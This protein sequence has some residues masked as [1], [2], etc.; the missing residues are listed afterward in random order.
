[1]ADV[2][3]EKVGKTYG[4]HRI[5][6][7]FS[8]TIQDGECFTFLGPSG[9]GKTVIL[10]LIAGFERLTDGRIF[11]G[12]QLVSSAKDNI[13]LPPE[14]RKIGMVFQDYAVWPH[15]S[16]SENIVYPLQMQKIEAAAAKERTLAAVNLVNLTGLE[17]RMPFQLS[18]G[19]QQ[20]VALARALVSRPRVMLLDEPLSNLDANLREEMRF[21][22]TTLQK[23]TGVT[24]LYVTHDQEVA[25]AISD[26]VAV[27]D[28][29]G[30]I[31][32]IG[33]PDDIYEKPIDPFVFKFMGISNFIPLEYRNGQ[34]FI[35]ESDALLG[36]PVPEGS[37]DRLQS[38]ELIAGC[39]PYD[40]E[41]VHQEGHTQGTIQ[42][43]IYL[44]ATID[45]RVAVGGKI[46]RVQQDVR[47][48]GQGGIPFRAGDSVG[49]KFRDLKWFEN[50]GMD[51]EGES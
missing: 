29:A 13:H 38:H 10:R 35:R 45:Y 47:D 21:E 28:K 1:M 39:R 42:R 18:G 37:L 41:L 15:K 25:L 14:A 49:L 11:I 4:K 30:R 43:V 26:R 23:Q 8:V 50:R 12:D 44:G 9:C 34:V 5:I 20:R 3:L 22:I 16:V 48:A 36:C 19:Q 40:I 6:S 2:T 17:T 33:P 24:I 27:M 46:L 32:Q 31:R 7:D 51:A